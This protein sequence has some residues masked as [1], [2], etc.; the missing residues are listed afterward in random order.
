MKRF[1]ENS[2]KA[3]CYLKM[4]YEIKE[5]DLRV[6]LSESFVGKDLIGGHLHQQKPCWQIIQMFSQGMKTAFSPFLM[7]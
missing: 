5:S 1:L 4:R 7:E 6:L 3:K 2:N